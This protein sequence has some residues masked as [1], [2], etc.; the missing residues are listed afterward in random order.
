MK[1]REKMLSDGDGADVRRRLDPLTLPMNTANGRGL[2]IEIDMA[3]G[4][5]LEHLVMGAR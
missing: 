3:R 1:Q 5:L 2:E 4:G